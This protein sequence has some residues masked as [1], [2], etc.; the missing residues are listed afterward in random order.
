MLILL[1]SVTRSDI[2]ELYQFEVI[3][4]FVRLNALVDQFND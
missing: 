3:S 2:N 4:P 1:T